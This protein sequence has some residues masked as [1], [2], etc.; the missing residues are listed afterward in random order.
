MP[1]VL[2]AAL[3][4][5]A[6]GRAHSFV[7]VPPARLRQ[8]PPAGGSAALGAAGARASAR[9]PEREGKEGDAGVRAARRQALAAFGTCTGV[10]L[11]TAYSS[12]AAAPAAPAARVTPFRLPLAVA[13]GT[14]CPCEVAG[15]GD[16][17]ATEGA[18]AVCDVTFQQVS[19]GLDA[20]Y[21]FVDTASHYNNERSVG[22]G[23]RER[24]VLWMI[25]WVTREHSRPTCRMFG[26]FTGCM[27]TCAEHHCLPLPLCSPP[28]LPPRFSSSQRRRCGG[29]RRAR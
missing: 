20:G 5:A 26:A 27:L 9:G 3:I 29:E 2:A 28:L 17:D 23:E 4:L 19:D 1:A 22:R 25:V 24:V 21:R 8:P 16:E 12:A 13:L 15:A 10:G 18:D 6:L 11:A 14:C 7:C